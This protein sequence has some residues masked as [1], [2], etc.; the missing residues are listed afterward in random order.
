MLALRFSAVALMAVWSFLPAEA[1]QKD[2]RPKFETVEK[3]VKKTLAERRGY[4]PGDILSHSDVKKALEAVEKAG[5]KP[6]D[7]AEILGDVLGDNDYLVRQL[8][9]RR[10]VP[11]MRKLSGTPSTYDRLDRLRRLRF[12]KRRIRE[13]I[14]NPGGHT[15][16]LYMATTRGGRN[17]G[18]Y[19]SATKGGK[20]F[21]R[22]TGRIYTEEDLLKRLKQSYDGKTAPRKKSDKPPKTAK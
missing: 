19:L 16:I 22:Q 1:A 2:D 3:T 14:N 10:G 5:W 9:T 18:R 20:N 4:R 7:R 13:L 17:L 21:N 6:S 11:F 12:G 15:L 8:R